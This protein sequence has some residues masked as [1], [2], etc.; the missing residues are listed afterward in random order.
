MAILRSVWQKLSGQAAKADAIKAP[1]ASVPTSPYSGMSTYSELIPDQ[2]LPL[3]HL[4]EQ[5]QIIEVKVSGSTRSHQTLIIAIDT[6]RGF[7]W[8]DDLFP[9]QNLLELG[10][11]ITIRHHRNGEQL[12]FSAPIVAWGSTYGASGLAIPLPEYVAYEPR[13]QH[14][15][16]DLSNYSSHNV[17]IRPV[18][19][20][21]SFGTIQDIS[22]SGLRISVPGNLLG[23]L[24]HNAFVPVCELSLSD[25]LQIRCSARIRAFR[26][27][28][29]PH[30]CTHISVEFVDLPRD[31]QQ[32]L[33]EFI[34]NLSYLQQQ[35][36]VS[37]RTA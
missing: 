4:Q 8:L 22:M 9:S 17:K 14:R 16:C 27:V 6:Q 28:R 23:Q 12:C 32:R 15:R 2:Y 21:T 29:A 33:Q 1:E 20:E 37:L 35:E 36:Q 30:R 5:R 3:W 7:L 26:L 24:R 11:E 31:R 18:G 25:E 13:R 19:Q 34:N 10:D